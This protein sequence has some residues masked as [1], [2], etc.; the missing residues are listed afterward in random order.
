M[1][2]PVESRESRVEN[3]ANP[4]P[5]DPRPSTLDSRQ[6]P[7][8]RAWR[9]FCANRLAA[10]SA[11]FLALVL[12][13]AVAYP[14]F[15]AWRP[16]QLSDAAF[17]PP[18]GQHWLGTDVHGRDLLVRLCC[19]AQISLLIGA[20]GAGVSLVIGLLWGAVAGYAGGRLDGAMMRVVDVLYAL[21]S[22]ILAIVLMSV[23][24]QPLRNALGAAGLAN[25][26]KAA[27][28]LVLFLALGAVSW[29]TMARIVR[30]Q[31]LSLRARPFVEAS[32]SNR[33]APP[34]P[35]SRDAR[36]KSSSESSFRK[37]PPRSCRS[38]WPPAN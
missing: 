26:A 37:T 7:A 34:A 22:I 24:E 18:T 29:L 27:R 21:P 38:R 31:V 4:P 11:V 2:R 20:V 16:E 30:G 32:P 13:F 33:P 9:R 25:A 36:C 35:S 14:L 28:L 5:S 12:A 19:G 3:P 8:A 17:Q 15:S 1:N 6:S 10:G 23:L